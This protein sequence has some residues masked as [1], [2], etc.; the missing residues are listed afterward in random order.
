MGSL[1]R[2]PPPP[3]V[4]VTA[5]WLGPSCHHRRLQSLKLGMAVVTFIEVAW[6]NPK[7]DMADL[8]PSR[9]AVNSVSLWCLS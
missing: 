7:K 3:P 6:D 4:T 5:C 2:P 8:D 1:L 9:L